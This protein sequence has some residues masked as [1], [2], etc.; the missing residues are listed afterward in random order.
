[1]DGVLVSTNEQHYRSWERLT[2][3]EGIGF[4]RRVNRRLLGRERME[5]LDIVLERA[6]RTYS[7]EEKQEL[8]RRKN[9]YF[10]ELIEEL[11]PADTRSGVRETIEELRRRGL[12]VAVASSSRN[13]PHIVERLGLAELLQ[14]CVS[15]ADIERGKP[16]PEVYLRAAEKLGVPPRRCLAVEDAP[17]GVEAARRAGMRVLGVSEEPLPGADLTVASLAEVSVDQMLAL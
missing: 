14:V 1:M 16:D 2:D 8:A 10:H 3:E 11:S 5:S 6:C 4:N 13:A 15:G 12:P 9:A 17:A 7:T